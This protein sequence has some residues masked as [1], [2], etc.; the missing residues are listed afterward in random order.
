[1]CLALLAPAT[2]APSDEEILRKMHEKIMRAHMRQDV[3]MLLEDAAPEFIQANRGEIARP[4]PE[5]RKKRLGA[6]LQ[7]T[8]FEKYADMTTPIVRISSDGTLGW[9]I[10]QVEARGEQVTQE[11]KKEPLE[12]VSAWIELYEKR[13]GK[14]YCVGNV[15]NFK[16]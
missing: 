7:R 2:G 9:V 11:G 12:F 3:D 8:T 16:S 6:Y 5:E 1:M 10:V 15:S 4:T 13:D 14:W